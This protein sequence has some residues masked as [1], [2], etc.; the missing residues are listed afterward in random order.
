MSIAKIVI[1]VLELMFSQKTQPFPYRK[2]NAYKHYFSQIKNVYYKADT[3]YDAILL[4]G[5]RGT[6]DHG[7]KIA[8]NKFNFLRKERVKV[9]FGSAI[10]QWWIK[11]PGCNSCSLKLDAKEGKD[12]NF[13]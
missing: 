11:Y 6:H 12:F 1:E 2:G 9:V 8:A 10:G 3:E 7:G 5:K 13:V 4:V